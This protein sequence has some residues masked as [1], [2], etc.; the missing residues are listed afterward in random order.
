MREWVGRWA[1]GGNSGKA[2][3]AVSGCKLHQEKEQKQAATHPGLRFT[4]VKEKGCT[5]SPE[6]REVGEPS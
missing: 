3:S 4:G 6:L 5:C 1:E 2:L